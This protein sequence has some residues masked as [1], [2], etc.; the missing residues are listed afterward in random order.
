MTDTKPK[1]TTEKLANSH[2]QP[3]KA[4]MEWEFDMPEMAE[5]DIRK[6]FFNPTVP[7]IPKQDRE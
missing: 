6:A 1:T 3:T 7:G 5:E 2:Y 4:E